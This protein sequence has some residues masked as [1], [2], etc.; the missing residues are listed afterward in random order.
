M[1]LALSHGCAILTPTLPTMMSFKILM[2]L[3]APSP[4]LVEPVPS[5]SLSLMQA[6]AA[7]AHALHA[8]G[9]MHLTALP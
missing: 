1:P 2:I 4:D 6:F 3:L 9:I 8:K 5:W 7:T